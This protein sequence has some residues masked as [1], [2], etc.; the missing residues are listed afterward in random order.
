M[1]RAAK[2]LQSSILSYLDAVENDVSVTASVTAAPAVTNGYAAVTHPHPEAGGHE[3]GPNNFANNF[4]DASGNSD[5]AMLSQNTTGPSEGYYKPLGSNPA[6]PFVSSRALTS[7]PFQP[8][9]AAQVYSEVKAKM[10][11]LK[12]DLEQRDRTVHELKAS[13]DRHK[14]AAASAQAT[15]AQE[16]AGQLAH[17]RADYDAQ[18]KRH[19]DFIDQLVNDKGVLSTKCED[20]AT[21]FQLLQRRFDKQV[22]DE[23]A[24]HER[25]LKKQ[26]ES[27]MVS[28]KIRRDNWMHDKSKEI[29]EMTVKGLQPEI[30]R[31]LSKHK[32]EL[33]RMEEVNQQEVKRQRE[34][35]AEA[36]ERSTSELRER[37][38][39]ERE[40]A[41]ER[42]RE[43]ASV[44]LREQS[45]RF[46]QQLQAQRVRL[47]DDMAQERERL[48]GAHRSERQRVEDM[49]GMQV[50]D[51]SRKLS[52]AQREWSEKEEE[53]R[54]RH[55]A[56]Q[57]RLREQL[58]IEKEQWMLQMTERSAKERKGA[59]EQTW[60]A[61]EQQRDEEIEIVIIRLEE[62]AGVTRARLEKDAGDRIAR[63]AEQHQ[64]AV[65]EAKEAE[66]EVMDKYLALFKQHS[67]ADERLRAMHEKALE[68]EEELARRAQAVQRAEH[69][70][71]KAAGEVSM[72]TETVRD[73]YQHKL[74]QGSAASSR[75]QEQVRRAEAGL[76]EAGQEH[77]NEVKQLNARRMAELDAL[78]A[79][80]RATVGTKDASISA[81]RQQVGEAEARVAQYEALLD[82]QRQELLA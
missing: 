30:E 12:V 63:S 50:V 14:E 43:M 2:E 23:R 26:R 21:E 8:Q 67:T 47:A 55:A 19:L 57:S 36:H 38:L 82:R 80:V 61:L 45:E 7:N 52:T 56:E 22:E 51:D 71:D 13:L 39:L 75:L 10:A 29:K 70:A 79:R 40:R 9:L 68:A 35:L 64:A 46:D 5:S 18:V 60:K 62:E 31:L 27:I 74:D 34:V 53:M 17:Q 28:E 49:Y 58:E 72:R 65:Q 77:A 25:E 3:A 11:A 1:D 69:A 81:L 20:L 32:A 59:D 54:R 6:S 33:R 48:D 15:H 42:E 76:R 37:L 78:N 44:R 66:R 73:E 41:V 16:V 24:K 4:W